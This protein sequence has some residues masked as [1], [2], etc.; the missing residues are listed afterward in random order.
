MKK[1]GIIIAIDGPAASGKSTTARAVAVHMRYIYI[2]SGAMYRAVTLAA[3]DRGIPTDDDQQVTDIAGSLNIELLPGQGDTRILADGKDVSHRIRL[4]EVTANI[5]PVAANA[6]VR[7]ILVQ[8]QQE[9]GQDGGI[10]MDGRDI[11]T[12][13]FPAAELKVFMEASAEERA[14]RRVAELAGR[15]VTA[16]YQAVLQSIKTRDSAD[17]GRKHGPLMIAPGAHVIDTTHLSIEEQTAM[18][19]ELAENILR[20]QGEQKP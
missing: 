11:T 17:F 4:P 6:A 15:G 20:D 2:D 18:I 8:K 16:D 7:N 9:L 10:V 14:R 13:V 5:N 19:C 3:L 1:N 12:V